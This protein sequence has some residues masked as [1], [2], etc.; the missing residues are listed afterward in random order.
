MSV[1]SQ[2]VKSIL[3]ERPPAAESS[4]LG[5]KGISAAVLRHSLPGETRE[6]GAMEMLCVLGE[7]RLFLGHGSKCRGKGCEE[8]SRQS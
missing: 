6:E 4:S 3:G 8:R 7:L 1:G 5:V 2:Q